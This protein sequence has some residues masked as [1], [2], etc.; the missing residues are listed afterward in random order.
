[1]TALQK[2][3]ISELISLFEQ[4]L[5]NE[6]INEFVLHKMQDWLDENAPD[7]CGDEYAQIIVPIQKFVEDGEYSV[8]EIKLTYNILTSYQNKD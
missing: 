6:L 5:S 8:Q 2:D 7:F 1:M 3:K 4:I